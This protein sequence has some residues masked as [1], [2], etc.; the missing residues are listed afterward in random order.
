MILHF[1]FISSFSSYLPLPLPLLIPGVPPAGDNDADEDEDL[2][3]EEAEVEH[4]VDADVVDDQEF[5]GADFAYSENADDMDDE[6]L[7]VCYIVIV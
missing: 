5:I 3:G 1:H 6:K 2:L 7:N 4:E